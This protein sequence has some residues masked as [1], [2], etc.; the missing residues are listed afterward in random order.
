MNL[1][2]SFINNNTEDITIQ[3]LHQRLGDSKTPMTGEEF[4]Q[5]MNAAGFEAKLLAL[6]K[7]M[8]IRIP[9]EVLANSPKQYS[10]KKENYSPLFHAGFC[11]YKDE[12]E[13]IGNIKILRDNLIKSNDPVFL[14]EEE[15]RFFAYSTLVTPQATHKRYELCSIIGN[16][17]LRLVIPEEHADA[18]ATDIVKALQGSGY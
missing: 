13:A 4:I 12:A 14:V 3:T 8:R 16:T 18:Y 5:R 6:P 7:N 1:L 2:S 15:N 11:V 17:L 10:A 9:A